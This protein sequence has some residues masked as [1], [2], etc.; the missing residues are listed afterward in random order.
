M[1][2]TIHISDAFNFEDDDDEL[3]T[4]DILSSLIGESSAKLPTDIEGSENLQKR[5]RLLSQQ[6]R[7]IFS[8]TVKP[9]PA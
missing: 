5:I 3:P 4:E 6:Y 7:H 2:D 9:L 1:S 8:A